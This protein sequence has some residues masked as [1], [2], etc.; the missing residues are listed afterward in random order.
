MLLFYLFKTIEDLYIYT[1]RTQRIEIERGEVMRDFQEHWK[2]ERNKIRDRKEG[3]EE[4]P[5]E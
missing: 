5:T 2:L 3:E 1:Y 4:A